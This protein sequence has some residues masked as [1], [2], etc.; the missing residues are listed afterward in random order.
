MIDLSGRVAIVTGGASGIGRG[1]CLTLAQQGADIAVADLNG[2]GAKAT[3]SGG[4]ADGPPGHGGAGG[5]AGAILGGGDVADRSQAARKGRHPRQRR[6]RGRR[7]GLAPA[8]SGAGGGLGPGLRG[9]CQGRGS[10]LG[11]RGRAHEGTARRQDHQHRLYRRA[12]GTPALP[13]LLPCPRPPSS[14]GPR[15]TP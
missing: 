9:E 3:G 1:I 11:G 10:D 15:L 13:A 4:G 8:T 2:E 6:G 7:Q 14:T 12:G 5:R